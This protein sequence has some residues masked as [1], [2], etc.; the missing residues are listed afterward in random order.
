MDKGVFFPTKAGTPQGGIAS[1]VLANMAVDGLTAAVRSALGTSGRSARRAKA[2]FVRYADDF[3]GTGAP[4]E[5]LEQQV[6]PAIVGFLAQR[7]LQ[8]APVKTL[9]TEICR[10][11][12][13]LGQ[14]VRKYGEKPLI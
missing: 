7:G 4:R 2:Q 6:K 13:F 11:F 10:A 3:V 8:L 12:D 5:L 14:N 1:P 9:V